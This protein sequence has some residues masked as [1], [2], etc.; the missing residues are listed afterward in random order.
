MA[1]REI[2][3]LILGLRPGFRPVAG[4][5]PLLI[6]NVFRKVTDPPHIRR[7]SRSENL[8]AC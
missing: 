4:L 8:A 7:R 1:F 5:A 3:G 2:A 6:D